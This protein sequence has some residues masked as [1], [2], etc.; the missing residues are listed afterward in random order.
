MASNVLGTPLKSCCM[1]PV[2]GFYRNGKCDT[3][4]EDHGLHLVCVRLTEEFLRFSKSR[5][6]DL[7]TPV[8]Q[9]GFS[10]LK[11]GDHWCL[12]ATRWTEARDAGMAPK[13]VL[14]ATHISML[15]FATLEELQ[16]HAE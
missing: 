8:P 1:D 5:G 7:S 2:T 12:C 14:E 10:G 3:G 11:E 13:V 9:W 15:E 6:N 16:A 4:A